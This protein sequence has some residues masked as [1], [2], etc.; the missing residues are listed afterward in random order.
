MPDARDALSEFIAATAAWRVSAPGDRIDAWLRML[1]A[2]HALSGAEQA[3]LLA[4]SDA[5]SR[6]RERGA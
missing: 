4:L 2:W 5:A 6:Q 1:S 3:R